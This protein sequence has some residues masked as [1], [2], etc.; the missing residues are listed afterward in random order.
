MPDSWLAST[1]TTRESVNRILRAQ[2]GI[3][4][5]DLN[6]IINL[7]KPDSRILLSVLG[8]VISW[9]NPNPTS[10]SALH[11]KR[12]L[13][14]HLD[15]IP[16]LRSL[17][18]GRLEALL[19]TRP[20]HPIPAATTQTPVET[21]SIML[22]QEI[23]NL[24]IDELRSLRSK[25]MQS[26]LSR[27]DP[28]VPGY[29]QRFRLQPWSRL[30]TLARAYLGETL[31]TEWVVDETSTATQPRRHG[32]ER[33]QASTLASDMCRLTSTL[34]LVQGRSALAEHIQSAP[35][36]S[37]LTSWLMDYCATVDQGPRTQA[38]E[39]PAPTPGLPAS[40]PREPRRQGPAVGATPEP[41]ADSGNSLASSVQGDRL[42]SG[43]NSAPTLLATSRKKTRAPG[44]DQGTLVRWDTS[45]PT[46]S[47]S[48]S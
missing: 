17:D 30:L 31:H 28:G 34:E 32:L 2:P 8:Q 36:H 47:V 27:D 48:Y 18:V 23:V 39:D 38:E 22:Q 9:M 16:P 20:P 12:R 44:K 7:T 13:L 46:T 29:D 37:H 21:V 10:L 11:G 15:L 1:S 14:L 6:R 41:Q 26:S 43:R 33:Q 24:T 45:G 19:S 42:D 5:P 40:P 4:I 25:E 3:H 35:F